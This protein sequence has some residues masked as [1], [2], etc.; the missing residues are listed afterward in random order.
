[1]TAGGA[2]AMF[3]AF[4]AVMGLSLASVFLVFYRH[5]HRPHLFHRREHVRRHQPLRLHHPLGPD[6]L[7]LVPDHGLIGVVI[8]ALV[9][10]F[11][12]SLGAAIRRSR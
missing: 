8:A 7:L 11:L 10:I 5:Q 3:W 9:N 1:M 2:Q 12:A 4:C 6:A